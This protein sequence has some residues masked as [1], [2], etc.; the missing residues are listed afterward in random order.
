[1]AL[2]AKS[3]QLQ[4]VPFEAVSGG[5]DLRDKLIYGVGPYLLVAVVWET[6]RVVFNVNPGIMPS[7]WSAVEAIGRVIANGILPD[8]VLH[9]L[10][11]IAVAAGLSITLG[12]TLGLA[13]GLNALMASLFLPLLRYFNSLSGIVWLPLFLLWFGFNDKTVITTIS[14]TL[15]FPVVFN[16]VVGVR[17]VPQVFR[18]A[19]LTMGGSWPRIV[20]DVIIPGAAPSVIGGIRLGF[21]Y[22]WRALIASEMILSVGGVGFMIF[23]ARASNLTDRLLAGM[24]IIGVLWA[25]MD[26]FFLQPLEEGTIR[27]WGLVQR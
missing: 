4:P 22:G 14:Y 21:A 13:I 10:W 7:L 3:A 5:Y 20:F 26:Y 18:S 1:M 23:Q 17:T 9:S 6:V 19:V 8:Y 27:R 12:V 24:L 25:L 11:R 15:L 2:A 16:T